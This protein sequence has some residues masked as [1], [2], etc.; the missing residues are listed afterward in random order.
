M[1]LGDLVDAVKELFEVGGGETK[2]VMVESVRVGK[3]GDGEG[4]ER[5]AL[6]EDDRPTTR[7]WI[8]GLSAEK[9]HGW[10]REL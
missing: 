1:T 9:A 3:K 10:Y 6:L 2:F 8:P 5:R 4:S 7:S